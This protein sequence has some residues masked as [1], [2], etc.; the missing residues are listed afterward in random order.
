M[1]QHGRDDHEQTSKT[2]SS[3]VTTNRS[4]ESH[5]AHFLH[6]EAEHIHFTPAL[7]AQILQKLP[8][9]QP[10]RR[11]TLTF[12]VLASAAALILA[13]SGLTY[14]ALQP[15]TQTSNIYYSQE[16]E[17][18]VAPQLANGGQLLSLDPTEH[19]IVYQPANQAG[20]LYMAD[21]ANPV[22]SNALAMRYARDMAWAPDGSALVATVT[23][24]NTVQP[25]LALVPKGQY[26][27]LL[28][29]NKAL[30]AN[31]SPT[32]SDQIMFVQQQNGQTKLWSTNTAGAPATLQ[33]VLP[34]PLLIQHMSWSPDGHS[35]AFIASASPD[36]PISKETLD[37]PGRTIYVLNIQ[38]HKL[39]KL[40][41][42]GNF[43]VGTVAW[44]PD[45][46]A[47]TFEQINNNNQI[48]IQTVTINKPAEIISIVPGQQLEGWSWSTDGRAIVY[49]DG[50]TLKAHI[51]HGPEIKFPQTKAHYASPFWLKNGQILCMHVTDGKG[52]LTLLTP[53]KK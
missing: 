53:E 1:N 24:A 9:R 31:W 37:Q 22:E 45:S 46:H 32:N 50:G 41:A 23:P 18:A 14:F 39:S 12:V 6:S 15:A 51:F 5:I 13:L 40:V 52:I 36:G 30:A 49:S 44:S 28:G 48:S 2:Q 35:L 42:A 4:M 38:T 8:S 7:R 21:L 25:L 29:Q 26:M 43:R 47:L 3:G 20:V 17:I 16:K 27:H 10:Q 11:R 34:E 33:L 19:R